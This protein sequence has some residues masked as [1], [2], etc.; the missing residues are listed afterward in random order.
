M[1]GIIV[2]TEGRSGSNWLGS[3]T[4]STGQHGR[5]GEWLDHNYFPRS[6]ARLSA[7]QFVARAVDAA[8]TNEFFAMKIFPKHFFWFRDRY[9]LDVVKAL[10]DFHDIRVLLLQRRD[11]VAQA[12]SF[13]R[14][15]QTGS[16]S[17]TRP[18]RSA[19]AYD[20]ELILR[21]YFSIAQSFEFWRQYCS[22]A[23]LQ[24]NEF[25]YEDLCNDASPYLSIFSDWS[26]VAIDSGVTSSRFDVQRDGMSE[27][28]RNRFIADFRSSLVFP[29]LKPPLSFKNSVNNIFR[30]LVSKPRKPAMFT[31][32]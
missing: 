28:W 29:S 25:F 13:A 3:L 2:L 20:C 14:A 22:L 17:S 19:P 4:D 6:V 31:I 9:A 30:T 10:R 1:K 16:W 18:Q 11:T 24:V 15:I 8:S 5:F 32:R 12:V 7:K 23:D 26:G 27:E 21:C